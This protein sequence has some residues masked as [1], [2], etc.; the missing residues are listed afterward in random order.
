[1]LH[2]SRIWFKS[3][4]NIN[5]A[6][7]TLNVM[8]SFCT[9]TCNSFQCLRW[10]WISKWRNSLHVAKFGRKL[11]CSW[12]LKNLFFKRVPEKNIEPFVIHKT[13]EEG[14]TGPLFKQCR[15]KH[16]TSERILEIFS[17]ISIRTLQLTRVAAFLIKLRRSFLKTANHFCHHQTSTLRI[18][19]LG[20]NSKF[21]VL[22]Q[23]CFAWLNRERGGIL[24][25]AGG[26]KIF[27]SQYLNVSLDSKYMEWLFWKML[28]SQQRINQGPHFL[29]HIRKS[30][31][32]S[33]GFD[34]W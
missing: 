30:I 1:M 18:L 33:I 8:Y 22:H 21:Q 17:R 24:F 15:G 4:M 7:C 13:K 32:C 16:L 20:P 23:F 9:C 12:S 34:F 19:K 26:C 11:N 10:N 2:L 27:P 6:Q 29:K 25:E 3:R 31:Q 14:E 28:P 5:T